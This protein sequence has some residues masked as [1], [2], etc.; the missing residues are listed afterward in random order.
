MCTGHRDPSHAYGVGDEGNSGAGSSPPII[1]AQAAGDGQQGQ[2]GG[3]APPPLPTHSPGPAASPRQPVPGPAWADAKSLLNP[4]FNF[5]LW[6]IVG[7]FGDKAELINQGFG[8]S[9]RNSWMRGRRWARGAQVSWVPRRCSRGASREAPTS[10]LG[11]HAPWGHRC[12][13]HQ[14]DDGTHGGQTQGQPLVLL[15]GVSKHCQRLGAEPH[16]G[17]G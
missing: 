7:G 1:L 17:V 13:G 11:Q 3:W 10:M 6:E 12:E 14:G 9:C 15:E 4:A 2:V 16:G 8:C 5:V